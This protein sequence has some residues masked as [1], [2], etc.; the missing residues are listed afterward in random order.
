MELKFQN[1]IGFMGWTDSEFKK[2]IPDEWDISRQAIDNWF[3]NKTDVVITCSPKTGKIKAIVSKHD[4]HI[5]RRTG[6]K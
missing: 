3:K 1:Y 6:D 2:H 4:R 5:Q